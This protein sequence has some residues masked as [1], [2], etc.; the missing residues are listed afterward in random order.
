M[1]EDEHWFR[2]DLDGK[3]GFVPKNYLRFVHE[4]RIVHRFMF[5]F[6]ECFHVRGS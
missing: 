6:A 5:S 2:A 4:F 3:E 1:E